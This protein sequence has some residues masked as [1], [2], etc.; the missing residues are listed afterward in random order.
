MRIKNDVD[1]L[2]DTDLTDAAWSLIA[3]Y[4]RQHGPVADRAKPTFALS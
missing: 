1:K 2:Y 4:C 3:R